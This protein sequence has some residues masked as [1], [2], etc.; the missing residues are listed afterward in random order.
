[1]SSYNTISGQRIQR[2]E[3]L[4][5]GLFSIAM[6]ILVFDLKDPVSSRIQSNAE[7][8][9]SLKI[10]LP[11]LL[12]YFLSFMT[13]G[14][15]WTG[16]STQFN[17]IEKYDRNLNWYSLFFLLFVSLIPF[18]TNVLSNHINN[19]VSIGIYW[20]NIFAMGNMLYI[21][22]RYARR[23][24]FLSISGKGK[25]AVDKAIRSRIFTAQSLYAFGASLCFINTYLSIAFII[26][27]QLN[28]AFGL[29]TPKVQKPL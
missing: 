3:A 7:L 26:T 15:F 29:I 13:L 2:I 21:H 28:Y 17:Y 27:I 5:D 16:Y 6:T 4:S 23:N 11:Q 24:N 19:Q 1:M 9:V 22:W 14:I 25:E 10:L 8:L 18:S 12:T 20:L